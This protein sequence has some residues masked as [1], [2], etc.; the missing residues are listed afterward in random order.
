MIF[1]QQGRTEA[2]DFL[3]PICEVMKRDQGKPTFDHVIFCT[4]VTRPETGYNR[5]FVNN[6]YDSQ[7]VKSMT[8]Q[9]RFAAAWSLLDPAAD[10][11]VM[12]TI[13]EAIDYARQLGDDSKHGD[14]QVQTFVTGSI[15][16]VG[17]ALGI[18]EEAD[19]L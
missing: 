12:G 19:A 4:N 11:R 14:D 10:V 9:H 2:L 7:E 6:Q 13:Q 1:N 18:L 8:T 17:G 16:L 3:A 5:A 15:H